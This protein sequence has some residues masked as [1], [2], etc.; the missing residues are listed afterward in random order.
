MKKRCHLIS[1]IGMLMVADPVDMSL[2]NHE[3]RNV[4]DT[5]TGLRHGSTDG[6]EAVAERAS[7]RRAQNAFPS[8]VPEGNP[9]IES[10]RERLRRP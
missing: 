6:S 7:F 8:A 2:T 10:R 4:E 3:P 5:R 1:V 9:A